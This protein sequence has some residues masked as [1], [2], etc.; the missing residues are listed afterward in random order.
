MKKALMLVF[1]VVGFVV[2]CG[3]WTVA[4]AK[5][6]DNGD[7]K[8]DNNNGDNKSDFALFDG[9]NPG[10]AAPNTG[11]VCGAGKPGDTKP[12]KAFTFHGTVTNSGTAGA[13][14]VRYADGDQVDYKIPVNGSFNFTGAA[15]GKGGADRAIRVCGV[16]GAKLSG[17]LSASGEKVFC[18]SCDA[19]SAGDAGCTAAAKPSRPDDFAAFTCP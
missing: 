13:V 7:N 16:G 1:L 19:D 6:N 18:I 15:G 10:N 8:K 17:Q 11:A 12:G 4:S 3:S 9:T 2:L 5:D 14:R